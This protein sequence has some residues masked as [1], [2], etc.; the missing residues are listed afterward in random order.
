MTEPVRMID[1]CRVCDSEK[2]TSVM[3]FGQLAL[4]GVFLKDG[5]AAPTAP[6]ELIQCES[7]FLVQLRHTYS[8]ESLYTESYG[9]ESHLN[10]SMV[11]HLVRKA[12]VLE[13][14]YLGNIESPLAVDIASNDGTLLNGFQ[15]ANI[16][17]VGMDPL[18]DVVSDYY[19]K[20]TIKIKSFFSA[21]TYFKNL[22]KKANLVTSNSVFYDLDDPIQFSHDVFEILEEDGVWHLEQSYLPTMVESLSYDT[23][24]H[25]HLLYLSLHDLKRIL[26]MTGFQ[27][28]EASLNATNGGSIAISAIK[29]SKKIAPD[30]FVDFLLMKETI[31]GYQGPDRIN[32]FAIESQEHRTSLRSLISEYRHAGARVVGLGASTK[33]NVLLQWLGLT[34]EDITVI[35][36]VNPRKFGLQTPGTGIAIQSEESVLGDSNSQTLAIV[37]PWHFREGIT[38][39]AEVLLAKGG[40]LLIPLPRIELIA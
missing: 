7:C 29:S 18:I 24:C 22:N 2:L 4:T 39:K 12:R 40:K 25:E 28:I 33:G 8:L 27:L 23:I 32:Q 35:G 9:Y 3:D 16:T 6:L 5:K 21:E 34:N 38:A 17:L 37:L 1:N 31:L 20:E 30:P 26:E 36:D 11:G 14:K 19:P 13:R 10:S 15:D